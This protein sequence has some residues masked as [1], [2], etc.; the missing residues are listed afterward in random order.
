MKKVRLYLAGLGTILAITSGAQSFTVHAETEEE[1]LFEVTDENATD[2]VFEDITTEENTSAEVET[3]T[4]ETTEKEDTIDKTEEN[5][6][7]ETTEESQ[8]EETTEKK[9]YDEDEFIDGDNWSPDQDID[10]T[11]GDEISDDVLTEAERKHIYDDPDEP[12]HPDDPKDEPEKKPIPKTGYGVTEWIAL[13]VVA[14]AIEEAIAHIRK[15]AKEAANSLKEI[16]EETLR[17]VESKKRF[18]RRKNKNLG[19]KRN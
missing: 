5:Q 17:V 19:K 7:E 9:E 16:D 10:P 15:S 2:L 14:F 13:G 3:T 18:G 1:I 11:A 8:T 12:D 4:E 6:K